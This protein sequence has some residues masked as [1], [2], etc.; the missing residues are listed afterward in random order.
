MMN[1][2]HTYGPIT[3][4]TKQLGITRQLIGGA[5][6]CYWKQLINGMHLDGHLHCVEYVVV[7]SGSS[8]G[9][10]THE[11]TE[12]IY[13]IL[14]GR[15][16]MDL[17]DKHLQVA[18]GDLITT[19]LG[20]SHGLANYSSQDMTFFVVEVYPGR[21]ASGAAREPAHIPL[22]S[23]LQPSPSL[24]GT[25]STI[26]SACIDLSWYFTGNWGQLTVVELPPAE[27]LGFCQREGRDQVLFVVDGQAEMTFE[28]ESIAGSTGLCLAVPA[29]KSRRIANTSSEKPLELI[30][31][32]VYQAIGR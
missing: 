28:E 8:I 14:S 15:A 27:E 20:S 16:T 23:R 29:S 2:A 31:I 17:N 11:K 12:E 19:P 21:T 10:H 3:N 32:E 4:D 7:P 9:M 22:R 25:Q 24:A 30:C 18:A 6:V 26:R 1:K 5:G 13:Y